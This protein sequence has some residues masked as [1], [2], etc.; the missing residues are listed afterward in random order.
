MY[1][2]RIY[3]VKVAVIQTINRRD[4]NLDHSLNTEKLCFRQ[5]SQNR[6]HS[7]L[8]LDF[9]LWPFYRF[10]TSCA[11]FNILLRIL[12]LPI[13]HILHYICQLST[14]T[15]HW[16]HVQTPYS[17]L[18]TPDFLFFLCLPTRRCCPCPWWSSTSCRVQRHPIGKHHWTWSLLTCMK[19]IFV[20]CMMDGCPSWR[21]SLQFI[22]VWDWQ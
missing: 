7:V 11:S 9:C 13:R 22:Q 17:D 1:G 21:S 4:H 18:Y 14:F 10:G 16:G 6:P 15:S 3:E 19:V 20:I 2:V 5:R 12:Y 8:I